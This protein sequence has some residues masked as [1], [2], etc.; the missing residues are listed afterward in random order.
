[1]TSRAHSALVA[2]LV[3][4]SVGLV[5]AALAVIGPTV[6]SPYQGYKPEASQR[7]RSA[8]TESSN[9]PAPTGDTPNGNADPPLER[10]HSIE[11]EEGPYFAE[12]F[13][14]I[15]IR[16]NYPTA[17]ASTKLRMQRQRGGGWVSWPLPMVPDRADDFTAFVELGEPDRYR[18]RV[19]DPQ[20]QGTS[21]TVVVHIR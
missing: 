15:Q 2:L 21:N 1:M 19:V 10:R 14:T 16:G 18:L 3:I 13:E 20:R 12:P 17:D 6:Q 9:A 7:E 8:D 5:S 4:L 11:L